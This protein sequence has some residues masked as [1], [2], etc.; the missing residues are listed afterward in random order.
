MKHENSGKRVLASHIIRLDLTS[1]S[2]LIRKVIA[3]GASGRRTVEHD[4]LPDSLV[5]CFTLDIDGNQESRSFLASSTQRR[6]GRCR[7]GKEIA[8]ENRLMMRNAAIVR[9]GE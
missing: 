9:A 5:G 1:M 6:A 2:R 3:N 8:A 4:H 7:M